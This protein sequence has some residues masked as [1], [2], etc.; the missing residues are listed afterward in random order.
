MLR[1]LSTAAIRRCVT[2]CAVAVLAAT[3]ACTD[4]STAPRS[5]NN[6]NDPRGTY[7]LRTVDGKALPHQISRSPF[8]DK[9]S[10]HF[11]NEY[12]VSVTDGGIELDELGNLY[13]WL[14]FAITADGQPQTG[15]TEIDGT[16][17]LQ[18]SQ[19]IMYIGNSQPSVLP[20]QNGQI[21][22]PID[23]LQKGTP[24]NY[25]FKR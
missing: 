22:L 14:N 4:S 3:Q 10:G 23:I 20:I 25:V 18:G 6:S 12:D 16:Y 7:A 17:E 11:Y 13:F 1:T 24:N 5:N 8:Y 21:Q 19:V 2:L 15:S 9:N